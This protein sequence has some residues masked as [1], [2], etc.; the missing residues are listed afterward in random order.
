MPPLPYALIP[1]FF[2]KSQ[3]EKIVLLPSATK[4]RV[5]S[6]DGQWLASE[7]FTSSQAQPSNPAA[8]TMTNTRYKN[9]QNTYI[10]PQCSDVLM[11]DV[12][13]LKRRKPEARAGNAR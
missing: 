1:A 13:M 12:L 3:L 7:S 5:S 4:C 8:S 6:E 9:R 10:T 11:L 2:A